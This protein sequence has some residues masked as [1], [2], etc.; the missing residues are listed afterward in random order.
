[1][2]KLAEDYKVLQLIPG[3][4]ALTTV[5]GAVVSVQAYDDDALAVV[6]LG[7]FTSNPTVAVTVLGSLIATPTVYDQT[8]ATFVTAS[9]TGTAATGINLAGIAN[10]KMVATMA[11]GT[12]PSVP[13]SGIALVK[14]FAKSST[15]NSTTL[16]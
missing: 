9:A 4:A 11:G 8:L 2:R 15:N 16:A 12:S 14:P 1:M 13:L 10:I 3:Q 7:T 5:T 6:N